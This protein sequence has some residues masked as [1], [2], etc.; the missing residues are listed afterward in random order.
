MR[1][2]IIFILILCLALTACTRD[3]DALSDPQVVIEKNVGDEFKLI[4]ESHLGSGYHWEIIG[5]LDQKKVQLVEQYFQ[6]T[7][8]VTLVSSGVEI[9]VFR[10]TGIGET[11]IELGYY[12]PSGTEPEKTQTFTVIVDD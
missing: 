11:T 1:I 12:P 3:T 2:K 6:S 5:S 4:F 10:A 7:S 9:W 8:E